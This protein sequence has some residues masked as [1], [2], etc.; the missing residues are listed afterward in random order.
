MRPSTFSS[1]QIVK[2]EFGCIQGGSAQSGAQEG[3]MLQKN[4]IS[5][6]SDPFVQSKDFFPSRA[7]APPKAIAGD[8]V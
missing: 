5:Q 2:H 3:V 8:D 4:L 1:T 7:V 6:L